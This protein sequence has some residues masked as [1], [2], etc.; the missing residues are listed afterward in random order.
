MSGSNKAGLLRAENSIRYA[1]N[2]Q[3]E[4]ADSKTD[5]LLP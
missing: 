5:V 1:R 2:G 3:I 4:N